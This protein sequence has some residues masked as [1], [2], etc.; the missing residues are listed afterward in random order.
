MLIFKSV[1]YSCV[2]N[3]YHL[4]LC[5][6]F[7]Q[8]IDSVCIPVIW[9]TAEIVPVLKKSPPTCYS[10]YLPVALTSI[11]MKFR[12][13]LAPRIGPSAGSTPRACLSMDLAAGEGMW[14][15]RPV[16]EIYLLPNARPFY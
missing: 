3:H 16:S 2:E 1:C 11:I 13:R 10:D 5:K 9:E 12:L 15:G 4:I 8:S 7:Q 14:Q 6:L